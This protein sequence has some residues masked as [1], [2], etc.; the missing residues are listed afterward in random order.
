MT[1]SDD[2]RRRI[3]EARARVA[4]MPSSGYEPRM[5]YRGALTSILEGFFRPFGYWPVWNAVH[6]YAAHEFHHANLPT[7]RMPFADR[8]NAAVGKWES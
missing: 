5:F 8:I 3:A 7:L 4:R 1:A 2:L 6:D